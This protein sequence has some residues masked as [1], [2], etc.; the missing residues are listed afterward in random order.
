MGNRERVSVLIA[1]DHTLV[2]AGVTALMAAEQDIRV[3][4]ETGD[5]QEALRLYQRLSPGV[6]VLELRLPGLDG[7]DVIRAVLDF[8]RRAKILVLTS[9]GGDHDITRAL[10]AGAKGYLSKGV[11]PQAFFSAVRAVHAGRRVVPPE[12]ATR[13]AEHIT[14]E[15]LTP[16]ELEVLRRVADGKANKVIAYELEV[17]EGTAK[18]HVGNILQK[19][20]C[21]SRAEAVAVAVRRGFLHL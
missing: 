19:L 5:G 20:G 4:G 10:R 13:V 14:L 6:L 2:R 3:V 9:L 11:L 16:R 1:D 17:S 18:T 12:I 21:G 7:L 8:D 15:T